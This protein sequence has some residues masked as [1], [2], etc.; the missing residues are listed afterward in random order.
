MVDAL[1]EVFHDERQSGSYLV[2]SRVVFLVFHGYLH[3]G[4]CLVPEA[5]FT[6]HIGQLVKSFLDRLDVVLLEV[7]DYCIRELYVPMTFL[8]VLEDF[9][10]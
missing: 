9:I 4:V 6:E 5:Y 3:D 10:D 7:L 8:E 1:Q 2:K